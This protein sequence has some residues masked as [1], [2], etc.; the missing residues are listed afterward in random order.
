MIDKN[1][2][3][4]LKMIISTLMNS[5]LSGSIYTCTYMPVLVFKTILVEIYLYYTYLHTC[6]LL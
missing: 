1:F 5:R 4:K 3:D 2:Q 6:R